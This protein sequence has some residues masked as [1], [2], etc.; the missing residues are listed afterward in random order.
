MAPSSGTIE[1]CRLVRPCWYEADRLMFVSGGRYA[2]PR[3]HLPPC[4]KWE[5]RDESGE[6]R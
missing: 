6:G 1:T 2:P 4:Q 3:F 5:R